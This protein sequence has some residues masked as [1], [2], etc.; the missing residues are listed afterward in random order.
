MHV[1]QEA[2]PLC[3][4]PPVSLI[5]PLS[6]R[7][8]SLKRLSHYAPS[9]L[10]LS[11]VHSPPNASLSRGSPTMH[12]STFLSHLSTLLQMRLSQE[13]LHYTPSHTFN[14]FKPT[15]FCMIWRHSGGEC[16]RCG[17][18]GFDLDWFHTQVPRSKVVSGSILKVPTLRPRQVF[19]D[20]LV[21]VQ[22]TKRHHMSHNAR[23]N[24]WANNLIYP[25]WNS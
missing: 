25:K 22:Q 17:L 8:V 21:T 6:A 11:S 14:H 15:F 12:L 3:T 20:T 9:H 18:V 23:S 4:F 1:S 10:S 16:E 13:A 5:C 7:C 2:L 19:S 24:I